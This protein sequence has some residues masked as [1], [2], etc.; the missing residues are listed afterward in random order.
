M[1]M[2]DRQSQYFAISLGDFKDPPDL[3]LL[4]WIYSNVWD[5]QLLA[6]EGVG[7]DQHSLLAFL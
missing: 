1:R 7:N 4:L 2:K 3:A 6:W 5:E